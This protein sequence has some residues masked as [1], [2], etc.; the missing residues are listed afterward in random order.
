MDDGSC[1]ELDECGVCGGPGI[2]DQHAIASTLKTNAVFVAG[3]G[4]KTRFA[5]A[6][7]RGR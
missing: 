3:P 5:I 1:Q 4:S 6:R 7:Q 2:V